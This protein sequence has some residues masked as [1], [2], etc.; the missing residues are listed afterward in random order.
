MSVLPRTSEQL[1]MQYIFANETR[2]TKCIVAPG[3]IHDE[4]QPYLSHRARATLGVEWCAVG[5]AA[6]ILMD[7]G[8]AGAVIDAR[9]PSLFGAWLR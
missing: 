7:R 8:R 1:L 2:L 6:A 3:S 5:R 4:T 9:A